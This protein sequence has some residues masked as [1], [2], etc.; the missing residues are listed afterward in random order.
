MAQ[1]SE[2]TF[3]PRW[4]GEPMYPGGLPVGPD[5]FSVETEENSESTSLRERITRYYLMSV[6]DQ[7]QLMEN[8]ALTESEFEVLRQWSI[9][10]LHAPLFE[11]GIPAFSRLKEHSFTVRSWQELRELAVDAMALGLDFL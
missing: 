7:G 4:L 2:L 1:L 11:Q 6:D 8:P 5:N 10:Y 3:I 9:Y